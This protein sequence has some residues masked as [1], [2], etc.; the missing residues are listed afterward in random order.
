MRV[1]VGDIDTDTLDLDIANGTV[2]I[3]K[4]HVT[5]GGALSDLLRPILGSGLIQSETPLLNLDLSFPEL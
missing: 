4:L 2:T 3:K 5:V 1:K